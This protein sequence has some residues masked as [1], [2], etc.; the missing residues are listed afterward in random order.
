[1]GK[2]ANKDV[3]SDKIPEGGS[4]CLIP[5]GIGNAGVQVQPLCDLALKQ[6][7]WAFL[8]ILTSH[9]LKHAMVGV[10]MGPGQELKLLGTSSSP[11]GKVP[12]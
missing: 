7:S 12:Q 5:V 8:S 10:G 2:R 4:L 9:W 11:E 3:V 1:M 6:R